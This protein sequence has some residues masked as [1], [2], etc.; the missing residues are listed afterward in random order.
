MIVEPREP[1]PRLYTI[2]VQGHLDNRRVSRF[3]GF[4]ATLLP[5]G[6]TLLMGPVADQAAL[7]GILNSIRDMGIPLMEVRCVDGPES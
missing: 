3:E 1:A 6:E 5:D 2:R 4:T 7:H